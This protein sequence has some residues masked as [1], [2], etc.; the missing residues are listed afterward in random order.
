MSPKER[1]RKILEELPLS[2]RQRNL[3]LEG[4][5]KMTEEEVRLTT[6]KLE[7][8]L[9]QAPAVLEAARNLLK[10]RLKDKK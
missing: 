1:A 8:S 2:K 7:E 10:N 9:R 6:D 4:L 3:Y 5:E